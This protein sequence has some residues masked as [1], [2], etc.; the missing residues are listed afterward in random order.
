M[1][2][3]LNR[4]VGAALQFVQVLFYVVIS[5]LYTPFM[6][7]SLGT[8]EYSVYSVCTSTIS[9]LSLLSMGFG[10]SYIR[11]YSKMKVE[12]PEGISKLNFQYI[13]IFSF[14]GTLSLIVG[15]IMSQ[16]SQLFFNETYSKEGIETARTLFFILAFNMAISFPAS[17]FTS[18]ISSQQKFIF[19][20]LVNILRSVCSPLVSVLFLINGF[21]S[22]GIVIS[23]I[24]VSFMADIISVV[25]C[26]FWAG[27]KFQR[28]HLD[29]RLIREIA[30]FSFF[31]G[32]NQIVNQL[33][34][35]SD[36]LV[37]SKVS[38]ATQVSIYSLGSTINTYFEQIGNSIPSI[39][40][41]KINKIVSSDSLDEMQK[42]EELNSIFIKVGRIQFLLLGLIASGF[43]FFGQF[44]I[45]LWVGSDYKDSFVVVCLIM[46]PMLIPLIQN[47]AVYIQR[48]KYLHKFRSVVYLSTAIMNVVISIFLAIY[49][50]AIG[51]AL[52][53]T[54]TIV[55]SN[56][57]INF[58]YEKK[59]KLNIPQFW[60]EILKTLPGLLI[61][62]TCGSL[63][64]LFY[65]FNGWADFFGMIFAYSFI[66]CVSIYA[67][68]L[69]K[70]ERNLIKSVFTP[71]RGNQNG[72]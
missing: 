51:S 4:K 45:S 43:V 34:F 1:T 20:K 31:I 23:M 71:K 62:L 5:L 66:Y 32:I 21:G 68:S 60:L 37:L 59:V 36:K 46:L 10:S 8:E 30:A 6:L 57:I 55:L 53:T 61:P 35:S 72:K 67:L 9:Y 56:I 39:F 3:S 44:F 64:L 14:F 11:F 29:K 52:G 38:T 69:N 12:N 40:D 50:G 26:V 25:Y 42:N 48:A 7:K 19:L 27:M 13:M 70:Y 24:C 54:I 22:I 18:Y 49:F 15:L 17:V 2:D 47:T 63:L 65:K 33:N 16:Y 58:Y 28:S 41:T